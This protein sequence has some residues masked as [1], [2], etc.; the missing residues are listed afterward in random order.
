MAKPT[1]THSGSVKGPNQAQASVAIVR[2]PPFQIRP[3]TQRQ[4]YLKMCIYGNY[5]VGKTHLAGTAVEVPELRDV[6]LINAES[7]DMTLE[8][9][10]G[11]DEVTVHDF[12][13]LARVYEYLKAHCVARDA[14][15]E[16][17]L[18]ELQEKAFGAAPENKARRYKTVIVD[19][20]S[21]VEQYS[22]NQLLGVQDT[23]R[24]DDEVM[25]AEFKEYKQNHSMVLRLVRNFRNLPMHVI[26]TCAEAYIQDEQKRQKFS[27]DLTGKLAKK[28]QGF[29]DMVGYL[30]VGTPPDENTAA[31][32]RLHVTP[33]GTGK[34]DAKH[35]YANFKKAYFDNPSI[36]M[37]LTDT[38]LL[39]ED[40]A[41][42]K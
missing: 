20:L 11:I 27:L 26:F 34:F 2:P 28:V 37:I 19:S 8:A 42:I 10:E 25:A 16:D 40:G 32:R 14:D 3:L 22:F 24:L 15:D 36:K 35:R 4:H 30:V 6:L 38:G 18:C 7:G 1:A 9:F 29:M 13:T 23:T 5:G 12:R 33:S 31:P 21:E 17:K 41:R 39:S